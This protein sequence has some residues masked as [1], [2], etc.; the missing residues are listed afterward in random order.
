[1]AQYA[2]GFQGNYQI[3]SAGTQIV[4]TKDNQLEIAKCMSDP[5]YFIRNYIRIKYV[6]E[7]E[8][9]LF[10]PR[11]YQMDIVDK[12][13][14]NREVIVKLPRQAGKTSIVSAILLWH[15]LFINNYSILVAAHV[16]SKAEDIIANIKGMFEELP[17]FLQR[18]V[19]EYN[20]RNVILESNARIRAAATQGNSARGDTYNFIYLDEF[21]FVP[22]HVADQFIRSV[23]PVVSS[24]KT[25]KT[26][27]TSTPQGLNMFFQ[28]WKAAK[29]GTSAFKWVEVK[30]NDVPGRDD[31]FRRSII[32]QYGEDYF[33]QEY[34]AEFMGSSKTLIRGSVLLNLKTQ[35]P[36]QQTD[37]LRVY[38]MPMAGRKYYAT[39]DVAEGLG[40]D[41]SVISVWDTTELPYKLAAV[42]QNNEIDMMAFA[43]VIFDLCR[44][45]NQAPV[46]IESNFGGDISRQLYEDMEYENVIMTTVSAK[47]G[48]Q[49]M[50]GGHGS[51]SR[52]GLKMDVVSKRVG[53]ANLKS[54]VENEKLEFHDTA[55]I[56]ELSRFV[57]S[58]KSYAAQEGNDDIC[59]TMV[60]FGWLVDQGYV[61]DTVE[62]DV[63]KRILEQNKQAI[64][65]DM[66]PFTYFDD[67]RNEGPMVL[68]PY[69]DGFPTVDE[70]T[71]WLLG[72]V[73]K[74]DPVPDPWTMER[75]DRAY[76]KAVFGRAGD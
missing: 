46:L 39:V 44:A 57:V 27:I 24:G 41:Y 40:G 75:V 74:K 8:L 42:Y 62:H 32:A 26:V 7:E 2:K 53:C 76:E 23:M 15:L 11:F 69:F 21:A 3:R 38:H 68:G 56:G 35:P 19:K 14:N 73:T 49:T 28:M 71:N 55:M 64:E 13:I 65:D 67:G 31:E 61:K 1:M 18:G 45:Y 60:M 4:Y 9:I 70:N 66:I 37:N 29:E 17:G 10:E 43:G 47:K 54:L 22:T 50:S 52:F 63:R 36:T 33:N 34:G 12:I 5:V 59:M 30:W 6:D 20:K 25:T 51:R 72:R 58:K 48:G 16:L